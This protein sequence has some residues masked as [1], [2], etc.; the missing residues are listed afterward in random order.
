MAGCQKL[1]EANASRVV[2]EVSGVN[3]ASY[4]VTSNPRRDRV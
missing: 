1:V 3:R 4:D 2:D